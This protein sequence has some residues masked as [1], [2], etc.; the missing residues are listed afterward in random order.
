MQTINSN[1][2]RIKNVSIIK[3]F[4]KECKKTSMY[5]ENFVSNS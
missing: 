2:K 5:S 4:W 3:F 1:N